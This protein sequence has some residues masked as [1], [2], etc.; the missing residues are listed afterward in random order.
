MRRSA[1]TLLAA[2]A[3][4]A[5]AAFLG[6][7]ASAAQAHDPVVFVHGWNGNAGQWTVMQQRLAADG[8]TAAELPAPMNY[9]S[10]ASNKTNAQAIATEV[11]RVLTATGA[12]KVD[13]VTH[14]MGGLSGR[15]YVKFLGGDAKVD[16]FVS[17]A[18][19]NHGTQVA[20]ACFTTPCLEMWPG[21]QFLTDLNATDETP[22]AVN[23]GT[24]W[25]ACDEA[26]RPPEST[27][28]NGA[29]NT[30]AGCVEHNQETVDPTVYTQVRDFIR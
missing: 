18:G 1:R 21:S 23:Y 22:G 7:G 15:W 2:C 4:A 24:W 11:N 30:Q 29:T 19:P 28:L 17:L 20:W 8:W 27:V 6:P 12:S 5:A 10:T 16:D 25:S 14:S 26:I 13:L 3:V 9:S